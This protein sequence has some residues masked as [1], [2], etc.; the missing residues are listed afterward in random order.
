MIKMTFPNV[1]VKEILMV[2]TVKSVCHSIITNLTRYEKL[3]KHVIVTGMLTAA[4]TMKP[5]DMEFVMI[6]SITQQG[7]SVSSACRPSTETQ[8]FHRMPPILVWVNMYICTIVME[9]WDC[10]HLFLFS[11]LV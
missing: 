5:K 2:Q 8:L 10:R 9:L 4:H 7:I 6:A 1:Y 11:A 3:V